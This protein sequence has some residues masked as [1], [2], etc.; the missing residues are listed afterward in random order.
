MPGTAKIVSK[1]DTPADEAGD[2]EP[3]QRNE[4]QQGVAQGRA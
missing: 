3:Q 4:R 2:G 1:M